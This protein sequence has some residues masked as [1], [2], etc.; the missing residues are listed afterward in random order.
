MEYCEE[1][2][3]FIGENIGFNGSLNW[4]LVN[5]YIVNLNVEYQEWELDE[6]EISFIFL[7]DGEL[8]WLIEFMFEENEWN[9][10]IGG[11]YEFGFG[12]GCLKLI[13][14]Q[15]NEYSFVMVCFFGG[16]MDGIDIMYE[17]FDCVIDESES[18]LCGEYSWFGVN[19]FDWQI[20][21]EGVFN[22]L[23]NEVNFFNGDSL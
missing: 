19:N 20:F 8:L 18:I 15:C 13:G 6:L 12:F 5:G 9:S 17:I 3:C 23:E 21:F 1:Y 16:D 11:D 2:V 22:F 14:L 10:E 7:L 4:I